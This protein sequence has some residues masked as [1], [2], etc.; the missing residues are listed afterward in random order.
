LGQLVK[1]TEHSRWKT[2]KHLGE[3][4]KERKKE[5]KTDGYIDLLSL[6]VTKKGKKSFAGLFI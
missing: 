6:S 2:V 4:K 3:R 5:R 1:P